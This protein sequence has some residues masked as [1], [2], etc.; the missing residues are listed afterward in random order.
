MFSIEYFWQTSFK[1]KPYKCDLKNPL[2]GN[3]YANLQKN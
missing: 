1:Q 3:S 2:D